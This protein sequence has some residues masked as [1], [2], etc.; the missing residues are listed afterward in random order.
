MQSSKHNNVHTMTEPGKLTS[1][2]RT[3]YFEVINLKNSHLFLCLYCKQCNS[4]FIQASKLTFGATCRLGNEAIFFGCPWGILKLLCMIDNDLPL[5]QV[6]KKTVV[7]SNILV[8]PKHR[9]MMKFRQWRC[10]SSFY[11]FWVQVRQKYYTHQVQSNR[12]LNPWPS[13]Y[14]QPTSHVPVILSS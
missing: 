14:E 10:Y 4:S 11:I 5:G 2:T 7:P 8:A 6:I 13:D 9:T 3:H 12:G 1:Q